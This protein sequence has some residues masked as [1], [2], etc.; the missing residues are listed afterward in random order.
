MRRYV[1]LILV[2]LLS[3]CMTPAERTAKA[4]QDVA[5]MVQ[6]YGPA[7]EKLGFKPDTDPWRNCVLGLDAKEDRDRHA[8]VMTTC[9]RHPGMVD[10]TSF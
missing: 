2:C 1:S 7:C 6:T 5:Q 8:T 3:A 4:E 10:C 9:F